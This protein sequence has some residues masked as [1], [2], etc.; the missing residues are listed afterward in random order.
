MSGT[1]RVLTERIL[2]R[3]REQA[4][5]NIM[6]KIQSRA[7]SFPGFVKGETLRD[8]ADPSLHITLTDWESHAHWNK[9]TSDPIFKDCVKEMDALLLQPG[10]HRVLKKSQENIFLL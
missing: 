6:E 4:V 8:R 2:V 9:W 7:R 3:G 5:K 1:V 10:T